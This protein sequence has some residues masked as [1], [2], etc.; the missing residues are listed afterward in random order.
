MRNLSFSEIKMVSGGNP[1]NDND[2][3]ESE[4]ED[5]YIE[6]VVDWPHYYDENGN[7]EFDLDEGWIPEGGIASGDDEDDDGMPDG[8]KPIPPEV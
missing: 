6:V 5:K 7:D 2:D 8:W 1:N 3:E 4:E